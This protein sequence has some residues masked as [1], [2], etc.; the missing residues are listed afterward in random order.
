MNKIVTKKFSLPKVLTGAEAFAEAMRQIEPD[1]CAAYPITPQTPIIEK[2]AQFVANGVVRTKFILAESEHSALS[3]IIGASAAGGRAITATASQGLAFMWEVL[4]VASGFRLPIIM[5]V[6]NRNLSAPINIHCDHSDSMGARDQG[7]I[8][9]YCETVQ[10]VYDT[11]FL[12]LKLAEHPKVLLPV[13]LMHDGFVTSHGVEN[14]KIL[15]DEIVKKFIGE[16][17]PKHF[18]LDVEHPKTYGAIT[19][20]DYQMEIKFQ[21]AEAINFAKKIYLKIG[22]MLSKITGQDYD[23]FEKYK[24]SD[25]KFVIVTMSSTAG[26]TK[27]VIDELRKQ[28]KKV[29]LLKIRLFRPFPYQE[30]G[31][32]LA[33]ASYVAVLDRSESFGANPPLFSEIK[34]A[35]YDF[36]KRPKLKSYIFG[37]GGRDIKPSDIK[38]VFQDL[39]KKKINDKI[40]YIGLRK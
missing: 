37:I 23:Y 27:A 12:A 4:G 36:K 14:V 15:K 22:K 29:G 28:G 9:I 30:V 17:K 18:L 5:A 8:Q 21:Q 11:V 31:K 34:N 2:F 10:E 32:A 19:F 26:T 1:V 38:K 33:S 24:L 20:P 3:A 35:L 7:W 6:A 40:E 13:M 25:A 16:Y 39:Q